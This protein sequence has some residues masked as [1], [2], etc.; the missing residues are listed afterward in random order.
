MLLYGEAEKLVGMN[1][2]AAVDYITDLA[3]KLGYLDAKT[4]TVNT[5]VIASDVAFA[6]EVQSKLGDRIKASATEN[7][8]TVDIDTS[9]PFSL[10]CELNELKAKYPERVDIQNVTL[11]EY[12]LAVRLSEREGISVVAAL[13]YDSAEMIKKICAAHDTLEAYATEDYLEAKRE[14]TGIFNKSMGIVLAG[15][16]N[17]VYMKNILSH[18]GTYYYG[19]IYQAYET[20]AI[21]Y[22]SV[23]EIKAFGDSM[24]DYEPSEATVEAIKNELGLTDTGVLENED[25]KITVESIIKFCDEYVAENELPD[26]VKKEIMS[27]I[28]DA[29]AA[30]ELANKATT[31]MYAKDMANLKTQIETVISTIN[32]AYGTAKLLMSAQQKADVEACLADLAQ[33]AENVGKIMT[34]GI[35]LSEIDVLATEAEEKADEMLTKIK[36]DL[37]AD[38]LKAAED[39]IEELKKLQSKLTTDFE[40]R[41]SAAEEEAR[42]YI[43]ESK[44]AREDANSAN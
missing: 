1:Y 30:A 39:R 36:A 44:K 25:G 43:E 42:K 35:T 21:T 9:D 20:S 3:V 17:E 13:K 11:T 7:G 23:Y 24:L 10:L 4:G 40:A 19:A 41:L 29:K 33:V 38:E 6:K 16:Y 18:L 8:I 22:R 5:S 34:D 31:T 15:A 14:A 32:T 2:E 27:I 28:A 26:D 12:K 37:S